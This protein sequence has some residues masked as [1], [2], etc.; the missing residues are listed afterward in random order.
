MELAAPRTVR[1]ATS[2]E[3]GGSTDSTSNIY[4]SDDFCYSL[5]STA[6]STMVGPWLL[7]SGGGPIGYGTPDINHPCVIEG[8]TGSKYTGVRIG[9]Q[10]GSGNSRYPLPNVGLMA[11][12]ST[13][14]FRFTGDTTSVII[15][16]G[17]ITP[18]NWCAI[19]YN[20][21]A[22]DTSYMADCS[23]GITRTRTS[24]GVI[25][26]SGDWVKA[27]IRSST[28]GTVLFSICQAAGSSGCTLGTEISISTSVPYTGTTEPEYYVA[29]KDT[30]SR[31][32]DVS[33]WIF[34]MAVSQ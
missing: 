15:D 2:T 3:A 11:F 24:L 28:A 20:T 1:A 25:P 4:V 12:D 33:K 23:N 30:N 26:A 9:D 22:G 27:R 16:A 19:V 8:K 31:T 17:F 29:S 18:S 13:F 7:W 21:L 5:N 32:L 6:N 34:Q 10:N 14:I